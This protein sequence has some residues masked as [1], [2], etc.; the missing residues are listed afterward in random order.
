[1]IFKEVNKMNNILQSLEWQ[2]L[3]EREREA[4]PEA[5]LEEI[6]EKRSWSN[7]EILW[8]IKRL[9]FYY[10]LHDQVLKKAP[11]DKI[12]DNFVNLMRGLYMVFDQ[13]NPQL[14]DN[15]RTYVTTR[16]TDATWGISSG[17]RSYLSKVS[18]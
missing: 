6:L 12:F 17:T 16:I 2:E 11:V 7:V 9:I 14:D 3:M 1:M 4:G 5:L 8:T 13:A 15:V 18:E 10:A